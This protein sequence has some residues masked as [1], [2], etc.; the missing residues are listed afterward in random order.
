MHVLDRLKKWYRG[1]P[2]II[3]YQPIKVERTPQP[4]PFQ[5]ILEDK[6]VKGFILRK[7]ESARKLSKRGDSF[8]V[9][10]PKSWV[11]HFK[12][13]LKPFLIQVQNSLGICY[14]EAENDE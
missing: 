11:T 12:G 1:Q 6:R 3:V 2:E 8:E 9:S 10:V 14:M 4:T 5:L 7:D 13:K